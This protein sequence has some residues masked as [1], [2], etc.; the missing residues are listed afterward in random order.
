[1][2]TQISWGAKSVLPWCLPAAKTAP[3]STS[4]KNQHLRPI[5][6]WGIGK[7]LRAMAPSSVKSYARNLRR[8]P[9]NY[10]GA[11]FRIRK[12]GASTGPFISKPSDMSCPAA[13][14][15][16]RSCNSFS[17][18]CIESSYP[19][20]DIIR[21]LRAKSSTALPNYVVANFFRCTRCRGKVK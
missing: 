16:R 18:S 2:A 11:P 7:H 21:R 10:S 8:W 9:H 13:T 20:V 19:S 3:Q 1:M 5:K 15:P 12:H 17:P 14:L 4:H 6:P